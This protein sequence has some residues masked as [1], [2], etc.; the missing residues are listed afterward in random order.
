MSGKARITRRAG[1]SRPS[2]R[3]WIV[4]V[5][6][7]AALAAGTAAVVAPAIADVSRGPTLMACVKPFDG[8]SYVF[9]RHPRFC[10]IHFANKPW[11]GVYL[12]A[13]S[14]IRWLHW[15]RYHARGHGTFHGNMNYTAP[16]T[17]V[18]SRPRR[19]RNGTRNYTW[20]TVIVTHKSSGPLAACHG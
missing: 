13:V 10:I 3:G 16:A 9:R 4:G 2:T 8:N 1:R 17:I 5:S 15:G 20:A 6:L 19:C 7:S 12:D 11:A 14:G 18:V